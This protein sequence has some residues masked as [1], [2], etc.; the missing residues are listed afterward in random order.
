MTQE[1]PFNT[2]KNSHGVSSSI[3]FG[4]SYM[5]DSGFA[6]FSLSSFENDY[7]VPGEHA[8]GDTLIE[9][10]SDRFEFRSEI[11]IANSDLLTGIDLN[12]GFGDYQH[13]ESGYETE[14]NVT[15]WHTH[16]TYL[17]EGFEGKIAFKHEIGKLSGVFGIHG[18]FDEF[19]IVG[20]ESIFG[21]L[22]R[23]WDDDNTSAT[24]DNNYSDPS[25]PSIEGEESSRISLFLIE[26]YDLSDD[27]T[28]NAGIRWESIKRKYQSTIADRDETTFSAS[29]GVSHDLNELWNL[30]G[31]V[32]YSERTPDSAE[33]YS[34]GAHHATEAYEI[35]NSN[36]ENESA[37]GVEIIIRKTVGKVTGQFSAF[38][39]EYNDY[40]FL[41]HSGIERGTDGNPQR[42]SVYGGDGFAPGVEGLEE[43]AYESVD[44]EFQGFEVE[45]DWLAM[46][47]PGW[48]LLLSFYGDTLRGKNKTEGG[49]L[50][51]IP[52]SRL[53]IGFEVMQEKLDFGMKLTRSLKQDKLGDDEEVTPAFSLVNAFASYDVSFG[54]S[55]GELFVKGSNLT[56][57][58]AYNHA[59]VLKQF[60]PLPGRSVEIGLKFDF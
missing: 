17:R 19:K 51:R 55:V 15:E 2:V 22:S 18:L 43:K 57:E 44:A 12:F 11:D 42:V 30:S 33:L 36:L 40:I 5:L 46:E 50:P 60:A 28:I 39:T 29:G 38:H 59:S 26:E 1:G 54:D 37:V 14:N 53:G 3:G 10:E 52:A 20:E 41:E 6:G 25:N 9:M 4:A 35:G 32:N 47:N 58:L 7:G 21:G 27:T 23:S 8:E 31:N 24:Y 49:N 16:A 13:S 48:D 56:D 45:I 34:D